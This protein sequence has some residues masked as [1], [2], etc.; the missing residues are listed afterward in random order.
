MKKLLLTIAL[1]LSFM[2]A[3]Y[4]Q[5]QTPIQG[6]TPTQAVSQFCTGGSCTYVPLE[7]LPGLPN[8]YGPNQG[9]ASYISS[10]FKLLIGAGA[11][12]AVIMIILGAL[13]YMFSDIVGNK[14]KALER[15]R[16]AMWGLVI[17][18]SSYLILYTINPDL[19]KFSLNLNTANNF[20]PAP[21]AAGG[22][23][24]APNATA[25]SPQIPRV[26]SDTLTS[27]SLNSTVTIAGDDYGAV[28]K[29]TRLCESA[30][31][32]VTNSET[33]SNIEFVLTCR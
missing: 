11:L 12:I 3:S 5:A 22:A 17:L 8:S 33:N 13:T 32:R 15:I 18:V 16:G 7:P 29:F 1:T 19:T 10:G 21:N 27:V 9:I 20:T 4:A 26:S 30:G 28:G 14:K 23:T 31:G 25:Q 24:P 6:T 2:G